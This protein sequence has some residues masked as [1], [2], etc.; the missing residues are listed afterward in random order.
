MFF[1]E[2]WLCLTCTLKGIGEWIRPNSFEKELRAE[3]DA[4]KCS[5][6][7]LHRTDQCICTRKDSD[8]LC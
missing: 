7:G 2:E 1:P 6:L 5:A 3:R 4:W 8:R